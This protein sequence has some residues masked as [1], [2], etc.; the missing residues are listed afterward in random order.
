M[1]AALGRQ[2]SASAR[3]NINM[4]LSGGVNV[5]VGVKAVGRK[6]EARSDEYKERGIA[7]R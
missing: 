5:V 4:L 1:A 3:A 7:L 2:V 6:S